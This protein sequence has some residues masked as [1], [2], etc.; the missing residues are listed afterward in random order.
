MKINSWVDNSFKDNI[1]GFLKKMNIKG[2]YTNFKYSLSGDLY[3][4]STK[5]GLGQ[6]VFATKIL[7]M[8]DVLKDIESVNKL[9]LVNAIYSFQR[10][11][12]TF[13]DTTLFGQKKKSILDKLMMKNDDDSYHEQIIRAETRQSFAALMTLGAIPIK[14]YT[15]LPYSEKEVNNYLSSLNWKEP[16]GAGSHFSHL[17]FFYKANK[18]MFDYKSDLATN[19]IDYSIKWV[20][21]LQSNIDG[22]WH[23]GDVPLS[24]KINGA[25]KI[26]IGFSTVNYYKLSYVESFIDTI[27]SGVNDGHACD[28]FNIVYCLYFASKLTNYR[29]EEIQKFCIDRLNIY[30]GYYHEKEGGFSFYQNR[31]NDVYYGA[32]ITK[33]LNEPDIHGTV[34]FLWGITL[35][36]RI[37]NIQGLDLKEPIT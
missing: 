16:W 29:N 15:Y 34:M 35:I 33:G 7:H 11:D 36:S 23:D 24:Q 2:D 6:L 14:P 19:L 12:G 5:W 1:F 21:S 13:T 4:S 30:K 9:N 22:T 10:N 3:D 8:I 20:N 27:L 31:A 28:N 37:I 18:E 25:M 17:L 26:L 32:K